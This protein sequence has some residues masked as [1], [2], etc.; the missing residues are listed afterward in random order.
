[1]NEAALLQL[2]IAMLPIVDKLIFEVGGKLIELNT[3]SL[4]TPEEV[5]SALAQA[6]SAGFPQL[7]FVPDKSEKPPA[8]PVPGR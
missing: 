8:T 4:K 2:I 7:K 5:I 1:M 6:R 3:G